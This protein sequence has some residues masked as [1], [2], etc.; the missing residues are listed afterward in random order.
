MTMLAAVLLLL[1]ETFPVTIPDPGFDRDLRHWGTTGHRGYR[2]DLASNY[3]AR[4]RER[5]LHMG[6][7]ARSRAPEDSEYRVFTFVDARRY[8]GRQVRFSAVVRS[9]AEGS[10]MVAMTEG[11]SAGI[12]LHPT[13]G[14][15]R[16]GVILRV[17]RNARTIEIRF[18]VRGGASLEADDVRLDVLR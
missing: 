1:T 10:S 8:R 4:P 7:A 9:R 3:P 6:W 16:Q 17:P 2:A 15:D 11:A 12:G 14:W 13:S 18:L 5:W